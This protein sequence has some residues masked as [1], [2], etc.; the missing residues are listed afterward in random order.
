[1][2]KTNNPSLFHKCNSDTADL[3]LAFD[4]PNYSIYLVWLDSFITNIDET[5]PDTKRLLQKGGIL[6][7]R[8]LL[9]GTLS[10]VNKIMEETFIK[11]TKSAGGFSGFF[12][13]FRAYER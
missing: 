5:Q 11:F 9:P 4:D 13:M 2:S 10:A 7:A 3:F 8:S 12:H 1:M 6:V